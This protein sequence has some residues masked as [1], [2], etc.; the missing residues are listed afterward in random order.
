ML[1]CCKNRI[2][3]IDSRL[4]ECVSG[5]NYTSNVGVCSIKGKIRGLV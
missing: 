3:P 5:S 2:S 1:I 4:V